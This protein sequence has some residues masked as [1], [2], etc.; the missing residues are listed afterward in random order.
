MTLARCPRRLVLLAAFC[1]LGAAPALADVRGR[2]IALLTTP[3]AQ[4]YVATWVAAFNKAAAELGMQ[5]TERSSPFDA[6]M[7]SQ[8]VDD[9]IGQNFDAILLNPIDPQAIQPALTRAKAA[10]MPVFLII[11]PGADGAEGLWVSYIGTDQDE[12]GRM[13]G[14]NMVK[15]LGEIGK[16]DAQI[17]A[18]T[19]S[20]AQ[21]NTIRRLRGFKAALEQA[22]GVRL[23]AIEDA[24]WNT[25]LS[26]KVASDLL[27]RFAGRGGIDGV[28]GMADNQAGAAIKA[29][30][31]AGLPLGLKDKGIV[32]VSSNCLKEGIANIR[33]GR[34]FSTNTQIPAEEAQ[35]AAQKLVDFFGGKALR[36]NEY[37][38]IAAITR[39]NVDQ[40][41]A[42]CSY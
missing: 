28:Y 21:L 22:P 41:A 8:Q 32:V 14:E 33:A 30:E 4:A 1:A 5:V 40:Y 42:A 10:K 23:A 27:V 12:L 20:A 6:A 17:V 7:Q 3:H 36:K 19:G 2:R 34:Q 18:I 11:N 9:A 31:A 15:A 35:F 29:I 13:A 37:V 39:A 26:E 25:A 16:K 38:P 24:K